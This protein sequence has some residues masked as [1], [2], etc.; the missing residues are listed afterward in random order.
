MN[1]RQLDSFIKEHG[2]LLVPDKDGNP[3]INGHHAF[4]FQ[5]N[6]GIPPEVFQDWVNDLLASGEPLSSAV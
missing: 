4:Y 3:V 1:K 5:T 6:L 2:P